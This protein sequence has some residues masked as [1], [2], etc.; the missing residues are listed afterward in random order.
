MNLL[1]IRECTTKI[2][3]MMRVNAVIMAITMFCIQTM[4]VCPQET[5]TSE[6]EITNPD[7]IRTAGLSLSS[8]YKTLESRFGNEEENLDY[9]VTTSGL[10]YGSFTGGRLGFVSDLNLC[11]PLITR[12]ESETASGF[13]GV[14]L[15]YLGGIGWNLHGERAG[16]QPYTGFHMNY[17]F[18]M[19][20]PIDQKMSNHILSFGLGTGSRVFYSINE[21]HLIYI[22]LNLNMDTIEFTSASY[23]SREI[24][25]LYCLSWLVSAGYAWI[26]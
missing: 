16:I 14:S 2:R 26:L 5:P 1:H 20:D 24:K 10:N 11:V 12:F 4:S 8:S 25:L 23:D 3:R 7:R 18:L 15:G 9:S 19:E 17:M 6:Q 21:N 13:G 22:G